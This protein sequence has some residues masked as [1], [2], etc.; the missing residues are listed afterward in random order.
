MRVLLLDVILSG[1]N[2]FILFKFV[3]IWMMVFG[4]GRFMRNY[5]FWFLYMGI[6]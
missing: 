6:G 1:R 2:I 5:F 3:K 4:K